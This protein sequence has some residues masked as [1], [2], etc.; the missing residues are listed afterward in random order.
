MELFRTLRRPA[1]LSVIAVGLAIASPAFASDA[2]SGN[3][4]Q[5]RVGKK[6]TDGDARALAS[7]AIS[8][9]HFDDMY[10]TGPLGEDFLLAIA[11]AH[12][13]ETE[14]MVATLAINV[15]TGAVWDMYRCHHR[16]ANRPLKKMQMEI[17]LRFKSDEEKYYR[18]LDALY[19]GCYAN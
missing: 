1:V 4:P 5:S 2:S 8:K 7:V 3:E 19:P 16:Y 13:T 14:D 10:I 18:K 12:L 15:R 11:Y 9:K 17:R 6:V